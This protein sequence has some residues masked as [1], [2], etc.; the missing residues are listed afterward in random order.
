MNN[1]KDPEVQK[2]NEKICRLKKEG[3][4]LSELALIFGLTESHVCQILCKGGVPKNRP[5]RKGRYHY[6]T[7]PGFLI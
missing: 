6:D 2:R 7:D 1:K 5:P 3:K 4:S